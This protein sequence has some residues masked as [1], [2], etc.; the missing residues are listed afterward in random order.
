MWR[1]GKKRKFRFSPRQQLR[2]VPT[3]LEPVQGLLQARRRAT[4]PPN[5]DPRLSERDSFIFSRLAHLLFQPCR[6]I[7]D[8]VPGKP[9]Q[10]VRVPRLHNLPSLKRLIQEISPLPLLHLTALLLLPTTLAMAREDLHSPTTTRI[11]PLNLTNVQ[12]S[13][14]LLRLLLSKLLPNLNSPTLRTSITRIRLERERGL[15][16]V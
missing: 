12:M 6:V 3:T 16:S 9:T 15:A 8:D 5:L 13:P 1:K 4:Q 7:P 2:S 11:Y 10:L 14:F